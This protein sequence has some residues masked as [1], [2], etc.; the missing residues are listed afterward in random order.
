MLEAVRREYKENLVQE[1]V[2]QI[3]EPLPVICICCV[4]EEYP[5]P[6]L[7]TAEDIEPPIGVIKYDCARIEIY[8]SSVG[9]C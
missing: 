2:L 3:I 8:P 9:E 1:E 5:T 6:M 4:A 7:V